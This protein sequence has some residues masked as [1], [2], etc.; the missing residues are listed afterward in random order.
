MRTKD[1]GIVAKMTQYDP[2][3]EAILVSGIYYVEH[4]EEASQWRWLNIRS[5]EERLK[6][7]TVI[8]GSVELS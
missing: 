4:P 7:M 3:G 6:R 2:E 1:N 5:D 8:G